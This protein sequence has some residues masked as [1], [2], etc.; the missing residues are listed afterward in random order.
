MVGLGNS[1][2]AGY[3]E[4]DGAAEVFADPTLATAVRRRP[5]PSA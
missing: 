3:L 1:V 2:V 5:A 4:P